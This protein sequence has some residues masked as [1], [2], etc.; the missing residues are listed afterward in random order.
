MPCRSSNDTHVNFLSSAILLK[1]KK[2]EDDDD[3]GDGF[4]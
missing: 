1:K 2:N 4:Q 3:G